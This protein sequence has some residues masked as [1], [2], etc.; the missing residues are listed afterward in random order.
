MSASSVTGTGPGVIA[1]SRGPGNARNQYSPLL[2]GY[3]VWQG[4]APL[5]AN[6]AEITLPSSLTGEAP[7]NLSIF[8]AG[9]ALSVLKNSN[10]GVLESFT[11][12]G[13]GDY[14]DYIIVRSPNENFC[15]EFGI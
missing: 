9:L 8:V 11:V 5:V 6:V 4:S 3:V 7:G 10:A 14:V 2:D 15:E 1:M 12:V 13:V